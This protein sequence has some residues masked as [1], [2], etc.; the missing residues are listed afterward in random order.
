MGQTVQLGDV[1]KSFAY[2]VDDRQ[3]RGLMPRCYLYTRQ[4]SRW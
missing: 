4:K 3:Q 2:R 1:S